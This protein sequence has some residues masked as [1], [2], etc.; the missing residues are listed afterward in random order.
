MVN[1]EEGG[2]ITNSVELFGCP[3]MSH[4][5]MVDIKDFPVGIYLTAGIYY[6]D[7][8]KVRR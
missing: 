4:D 5:D 2:D 6:P 3:K 1:R 7:G 8:N